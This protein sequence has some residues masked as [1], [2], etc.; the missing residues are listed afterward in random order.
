MVQL[1]WRLLNRRVC[2]RGGVTKV[3]AA[4]KVGL[5]TLRK[6]LYKEYVPSLTTLLKLTEYLGLNI[7]DVVVGAKR[8]LISAARKIVIYLGS[9][10]LAPHIAPEAAG[11]TGADVEAAWLFLDQL[12]FIPRVQRRLLMPSDI[13][14]VARLSWDQDHEE[15]SFVVAVGSLRANI[16]FLYAYDQLHKHFKSY[17]LSFCWPPAAGDTAALTA[18]G[19][20]RKYVTLNSDPGKW[21]VT[22]AR[23]QNLFLPRQPN[24]RHP[25]KTYKDVAIVAADEDHLILAGHGAAGTLGAAHLLKEKWQHV[26]DLVWRHKAAILFSQVIAR[27]DAD[28]RPIDVSVNEQELHVLTPKG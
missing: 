4:S 21:G 13:A 17:E 23:K 25:D 2:E 27:A 8:Q 19:V 15:G 22:C 6:I 5:L 28:G 7:G 20:Y 11:P 1:D 16:A 12:P 10:N 14:D 18:G 9:R 3:A 24:P 26:A